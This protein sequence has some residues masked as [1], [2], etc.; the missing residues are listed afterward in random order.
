MYLGYQI[1]KDSILL[2]NKIINKIS[3]IASPRN[4][5]ELK[6]FLGLTNF[7]NRYLLLYSDLVEPFNEIRKKNTEFQWT[8]RQEIAF[9]KLKKAQTSG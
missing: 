6:S 3:E 4:K 5:K 7:Y 9:K 8:K 2:D 1:S